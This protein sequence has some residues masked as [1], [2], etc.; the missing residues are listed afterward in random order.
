MRGGVCFSL[1]L[2]RAAI[3]FFYVRW[4]ISFPNDN[5]TF[6]ST[7]SWKFG[8][9]QKYL[10]W[11][12][13]F[14]QKYIE[15]YLFFIPRRKMRSIS[16]RGP[17]ELFPFIVLVNVYWTFKIC[18]E[19]RLFWN[20]KN[21]FYLKGRC[22]AYPVEVQLIVFPFILVTVYWTFKTCLEEKHFW[23]LE[24]VL[25]PEGRCVAYPVG[26]QLFLLMIYLG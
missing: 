26:V 5:P 8:L 24:K 2:S 19:E 1:T 23:N 25:Y 11:K 10:Y 12:F 9:K 13:A 4:W 16:S 7:F 6:Q 14:K 22:V 17:I 18:L 3:F 21:V 20:L 15:L